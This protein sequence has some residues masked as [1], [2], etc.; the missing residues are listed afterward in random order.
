MSGLTFPIRLRA[1]IWDKLWIQRVSVKAPFHQLSTKEISC[2]YGSCLKVCSK[3][4]A[5][6]HMNANYEWVVRSSLG[7][8]TSVS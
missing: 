7:R 8:D 1:G 5:S 2:S 4:V 6:I 3:A